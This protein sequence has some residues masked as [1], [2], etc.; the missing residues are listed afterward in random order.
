[1]MI[2]CFVWMCGKFNENDRRESENKINLSYILCVTGFF[3]SFFL[4]SFVRVNNRIGWLNWEWR[5][6]IAFRT[7]FTFYSKCILLQCCTFIL[8]G[9]R[10]EEKQQKRGNVFFSSICALCLHA[11]I[12]WAVHFTV[13][14]RPDIQ[15][16]YVLTVNSVDFC[17]FCQISCSFRS[18]NKSFV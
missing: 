5:L 7:L 17:V 3:F 8:S 1:M 11:I 16:V 18:S 12:V 15:F 4:V 9:R 13:L 10:E 2:Q 6:F 14:Q